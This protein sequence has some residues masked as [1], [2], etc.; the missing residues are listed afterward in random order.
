MPIRARRTSHSNNY[1]FD[2]SYWIIDAWHE[3]LDMVSR[4]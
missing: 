4:C 3:R 1:K 2:H